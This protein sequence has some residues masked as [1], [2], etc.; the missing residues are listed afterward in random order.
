MEMDGKKTSVSVSESECIEK[1]RR[2]GECNYIPAKVGQRRVCDWTGSGTG[3]CEHEVVFSTSHRRLVK[4][5]ESNNIT[6]RG[7]LRASCLGEL[8]RRHHIR[9]VY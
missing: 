7:G 1:V 5:D 4:C 8:D 3:L 2:A 6:G 9:S